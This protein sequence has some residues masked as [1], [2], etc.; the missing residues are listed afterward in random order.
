MKKVVYIDS[1]E[2]LAI[3]AVPIRVRILNH[4][5]YEAFSPKKLSLIMDQSPQSLNY[6]FNQL[7]KADLIYKKYEEK[8]RGVFETFYQASAAIFRID[9]SLFNDLDNKDYIEKFASK[10]HAEKELIEQLNM[11]ISS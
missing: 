1:I 2:K 6:H 10:D 11:E 7:F 4:L 8:K 3:I 5:R 9:N